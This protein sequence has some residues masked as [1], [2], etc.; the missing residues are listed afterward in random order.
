MNTTELAEV[1]GRPWED[2]DVSLLYPRGSLVLS[3]FSIEGGDS[4]EGFSL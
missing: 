2:V 1:H 4:T 3:G